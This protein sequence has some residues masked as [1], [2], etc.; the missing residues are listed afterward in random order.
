V[1]S[2]IHPIVPEPPEDE[3]VSSIPEPEL[4]A[5]PISSISSFSSFSAHYSGLRSYVIL[6][7]DSK[8]VLEGKM[9][10][11]SQLGHR[12][13]S[14]RWALPAINILFIIFLVATPLGIPDVFVIKHTCVGHRGDAV[15]ITVGQLY[16][17]ICAA[18]LAFIRIVVL[19]HRVH[20][21]L[22]RMTLT[23][24]DPFVIMLSSAR[25]WASYWYSR[26][27][28]TSG[29]EIYSAVIIE[30]LAL[31]FL[32]LAGG[33]M[34][35]V[36]ESV[37]VPATSKMSMVVFLAFVVTMAWMKALCLPVNFDPDAEVVFDWLAPMSP[38]SQHSSAI[39]VIAIML[40]K[41]SWN[42]WRG[43]DFMFLNTHYRLRKDTMTELFADLDL[44]GDGLLSSEEW[45]HCLRSFGIHGPVQDVSFQALGAQGG[46]A[47]GYEAF[48]EATII[49]FLQHPHLSNKELLA[50]FCQ[51]AARNIQGVRPLQMMIQSVMDDWAKLDLEAFGLCMYSRLI[52]NSSIAELFKSK[53]LQTQAATFIGMM[54]LAMGWL[55]EAQVTS[56]TQKMEAL[57]MRHVSYGVSLQ[58]LSSFQCAM[59]SAVEQ[60]IGASFSET[61]SSWTFVFLHF[62]TTPFVV[63]LFHASGGSRQNALATARSAFEVVR[64]MPN[65]LNIVAHQLKTSK[66]V[67]AAQMAK[68]DAWTQRMP[69]VDFIDH[70]LKALVSPNGRA[71][72][73][74]L[75]RLNQTR[76]I[77]AVELVLLEE[78]FMEGLR[79]TDDKLLP[80]GAMA[81]WT[82]A[83]HNEIIENELM[84]PF[85]HIED[86]LERFASECMQG[87][88]SH[89]SREQ[90][91]QVFAPLGLTSECL[92]DIYA[93]LDLDGNDQLDITMLRKVIIN[94]SMLEPFCSLREVLGALSPSP[95]SP[96][97]VRRRAA[98]GSALPDRRTQR[99]T[100]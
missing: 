97:R 53:S 64:N 90:F 56:L 76:G 81:A 30:D 11:N 34:I 61:K 93:R 36:T 99:L 77:T 58:F 41:G 51:S 74:L 33:V 86:E 91:V 17:V 16:F 18:I 85:C 82:Y 54:S 50:L 2:K 31:L 62:I 26:Y 46:Q 43:R 9:I 66:S 10:L 22:F 63:G 8:H 3:I 42:L 71:D 100:S 78:A 69:F 70:A 98:E 88:I 5:P 7:V 4:E 75:A 68:C 44:N 87:D 79:Q 89:V 80:P 92:E 35:A 38:R 23:T 12:L 6:P 19:L 57:G 21:S 52:E 60:Q 14:H 67:T 73:Q 29:S 65:F 55:R 20:W 94:Q 28:L 32:Y 45:Q 1:F 40:Y 25:G 84:A 47:V 24:F 15:T 96:A 39:L 72:M 27:S 59:F 37:Q 13:Y 48:R 49:H 95:I 83:F